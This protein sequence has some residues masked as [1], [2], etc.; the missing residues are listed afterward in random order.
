MSTST[1]NVPSVPAQAC[2][3]SIGQSEFAVMLRDGRRIA[4]PFACFPRLERATPEQRRHFEVY[5]DGKMLHWPDLDEDIEVQHIV[6]GRMP[7]KLA[8]PLAV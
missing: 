1:G 5:A 7:V 4:V 6:D 3:L 2:G 8:E